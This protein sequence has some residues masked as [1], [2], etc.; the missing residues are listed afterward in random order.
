MRRILLF[1]CLS[2]LFC[3]STFAQAG[4]H[5]RIARTQEKSSIHV[6]PKEPPAALKVIFSNLKTK[7]DLY[8]DIEGNVV[9]GPN[10]TMYGLEFL[11]M[12][13]TPKLN[14]HVS[15][16]RVAVQYLGSGANQVNLSVYSDS[17]GAPGT[18]LA[19]PVTVNA[20][21]AFGTCC[22]LAVA[23]FSPTAVTAGTR[24]WVT[25]DTPSTGT[26]SDFTGVWDWV[27]TPTFLQARDKGAGWVPFEGSPAESA[28]EVLGTVP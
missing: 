26:G 18:L 2:I 6:P 9:S 20:L 14:S 5:P 24:Y 3:P 25:A 28:G 23:D 7:T 10:S 21:S 4:R 13:F 11:G 12:P 15:E 17:G 27:A 8:N 19:G 22:T 16:V 1:L